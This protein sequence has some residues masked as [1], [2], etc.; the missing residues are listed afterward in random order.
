MPPE[1]VA[2][3]SGHSFRLGA[4]QDLLCPGFDSAATIR[5]GALEIRERAGA[6]SGSLL[7]QCVGLSAAYQVSRSVVSLARNH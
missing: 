1:D 6:L 2:A 5:A 3:F 4:A 7:I